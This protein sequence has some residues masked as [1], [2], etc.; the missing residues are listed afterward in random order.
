VPSLK[1]WGGQVPDEERWFT[2]STR[3]NTGIK[4][5]SLH[6]WFP[7]HAL[8]SS[9]RFIVSFSL[10]QGV[11]LDGVDPAFHPMF[12]GLV[13][14]GVIHDTKNLLH[15]FEESSL[16]RL[17]LISN[18]RRLTHPNDMA[19]PPRQGKLVHD[20]SVNAETEIR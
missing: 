1:Q 20:I 11:S 12:V 5:L 16:K 6:H 14:A 15:A 3:R 19:I 17:A 18:Q 2:R 7:E 9:T 13:L 8:V 4:Y 10:V